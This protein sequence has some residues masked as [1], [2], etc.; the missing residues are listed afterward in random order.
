VSVSVQKDRSVI[1]R[2]YRDAVLRLRDLHDAWDH[3]GVYI[4]LT[5]AT[6]WLASL[7]EQ[8]DVSGHEDVDAV[9]F[10]RN[11]SH[12]HWGSVT[13]PDEGQR[14]YLWRPASQLPVPPDPHHRD[15]KREEQYVARLAGKPLL[16][17]FGRLDAA[18]VT[19][20]RVQQIVKEAN[21][22]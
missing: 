11:R 18:G 17:V 4:A 5:E 8:T 19:P 12:H 10:A 9:I 3:D 15:E 1:V 21:G 16:E 13:Y 2:G 20:Q 7:A 14:V 6:N 22:S